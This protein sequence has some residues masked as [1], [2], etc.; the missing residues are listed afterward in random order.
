MQE[1]NLKKNTSGERENCSKSNDV[2]EISWNGPEK[3]KTHD[4]A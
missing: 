2:A 3:K 1:E 4:N